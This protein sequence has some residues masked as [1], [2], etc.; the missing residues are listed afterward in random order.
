MHSPNEGKAAC[1]LC[2]IYELNLNDTIVRG[3]ENVVKNIHYMLLHLILRTNL[4]Y[5]S[6]FGLGPVSSFCSFCLLVK[7][8]FSSWASPWM[9]E[10]RAGT[11]QPFCSWHMLLLIC[12]LPGWCA[13]TSRLKIN[14]SLDLLQRWN[15]GPGLQLSD[16]GPLASSWD[17]SHFPVKP[18]AKKG[19]NRVC[20]HPVGSSL[21]LI[22]LP[23][24]LACGCSSRS[25]S[26]VKTTALQRL[27]N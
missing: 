3:L 12:W 15:S 6:L 18:V 11:M 26:D 1:E 14:Y 9:N 7:G 21:L 22:L 4:I 17:D 24:C 2:K 23:N 19:A 5:S 27:S 25:S 20:A 13:E 8:L 16:K 10:G